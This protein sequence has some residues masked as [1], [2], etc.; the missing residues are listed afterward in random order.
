MD[1]TATVNSECST[2]GYSSV[3]ATTTWRYALFAVH[4]ALSVLILFGNA[5]TVLAIWRT[6]ELR[7][8]PNIYVLN[9]AVADGIVG[10]N[11]SLIA[12]T[13]VDVTGRAF[14]SSRYLC[15]ALYVL[16]HVGCSQSLLL[17]VAMAVDRLVY[18]VYPYL[19]VRCFTERR[20]KIVI[21]V[22]WLFAVSSGT[23]P[24]LLNVFTPEKG[25]APGKVINRTFEGLVQPLEILAVLAITSAC[26]IKIACVAQKQR[27]A[28]TAQIQMSREVR[29][30]QRDTDTQEQDSP[31]SP[32]S[33]HETT[34]R[35]G[36]TAGQTGGARQVKSLGVFVTVNCL[37]AVCWMP[38]VVHNL[39]LDGVPI[40][41]TVSSVVSFLAMSNSA[42]NTV[43]LARMNRHFARAYRKLLTQGRCCSGRGN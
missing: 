11:V 10:V 22:S 37:F 13:F 42:M 31:S 8:Q 41:D 34:N 20:T 32:R 7:T 26:Y 16:I 18:V 12:L 6:P 33:V 1:M 38:F 19:Y 5:L 29:L 40:P 17:L 4:L 2:E 25:C 24:S 35:D 3:P 28:V 27:R 36:S 14:D 23:L 39:L 30:P 43:I 9:L 15:V 21:A